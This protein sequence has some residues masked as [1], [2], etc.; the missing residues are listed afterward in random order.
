VCEQR[1]YWHEQAT[2]LAP[3]AIQVIEDCLTNTN[4][5]RSLRF[6]AATFLLKLAIDPQAKAIKPLATIAPE[7][8]AIPARC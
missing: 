6:R 8:E 3:L 7:L 5:S 1:L 2:S 4:S